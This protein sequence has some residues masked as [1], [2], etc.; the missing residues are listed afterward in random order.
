[1]IR[2]RSATD[3]AIFTGSALF[4]GGTAANPLSSIEAASFLENSPNPTVQ[5]DARIASLLE[6]ATSLRAEMTRIA[7][8]QRGIEAERLHLK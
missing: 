6:E 8:G 5:A 2:R 4:Y 1:M 7:A 3:V